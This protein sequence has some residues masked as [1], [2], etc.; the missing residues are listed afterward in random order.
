VCQESLISVDRGE[1][2][3]ERGALKLVTGSPVSGVSGRIVPRVLVLL[4]NDAVETP[5]AFL[6]WRK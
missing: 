1:R 4:L 3:S 5:L 6:A 2:E